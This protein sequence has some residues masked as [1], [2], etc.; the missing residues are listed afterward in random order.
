[1]R[2][3]EGLSGA[4]FRLEFGD[5]PR[6]FFAEEIERAVALGWLVEGDPSPGDLRLTRAG[7]LVADS[8]AALFVA[9][10]LESGPAGD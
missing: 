2:R 6:R 3:R 7:R 1:L 4:S 9:D 8:V 10:E 5:P